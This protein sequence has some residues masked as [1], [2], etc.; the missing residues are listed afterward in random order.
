[1]YI[2]RVETRIVEKLVYSRL[3]VQNKQEE[4]EEIELNRERERERK[5]LQGSDCKNLDAVSDMVQRKNC[6]RKVV[7]R[8]KER[9]YRKGSGK[10]G[11]FARYE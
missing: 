5:A 1:M 2:E 11:R 10:R 7:G 3:L 4:G 8:K 9:K 6:G